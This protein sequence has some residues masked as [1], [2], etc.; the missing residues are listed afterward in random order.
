M[1]DAAPLHVTVAGTY[2]CPRCG[3]LHVEVHAGY[4]CP[5]APCNACSGTGVGVTM[6][7]ACPACEGRGFRIVPIRERLVKADEVG[8]G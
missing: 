7:V 8:D 6:G 4:T 5:C 2:Q 1:S 3:W